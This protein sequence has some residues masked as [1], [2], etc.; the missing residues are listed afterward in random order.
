MLVSHNGTAPTIHPDAWVAPDATLYGDVEIGAGTRILPGA[1]VVA[2]GGGRIRIA[3][4]CIVMENAV[5]RATARHNCSIAE[6]CLIGPGA[7]VVGAEV[8]DRVF[9]ATGAAVFHGAHL[10]TGCEVRIHATVHLRTRLAAGSTVPI[11]WVAV[12]D[13]AEIL[14][15]DR[16]DEIWARQRPLDFPGWVYGVDRHAPDPMAAITGGLSRAL[17]GHAGD[18]VVAG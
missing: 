9:V 10:E 1:R 8:A 4:T 6:H 16:H 17:A 5:I 12:G 2:E 18:R 14:P 15:P 7:H 11:G 13:P 3:E